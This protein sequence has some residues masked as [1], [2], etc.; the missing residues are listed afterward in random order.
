MNEFI[1][2][3]ICDLELNIDNLPD[4]ANSEI[5][6]VSPKVKKNHTKFIKSNTVNFIK[7]YGIGLAAARNMAIKKCDGDYILLWGN[8]LTAKNLNTII[9]RA[10][11]CCF[12][13]P[14]DRAGIAFRT[15]NKEDNTYFEKCLNYRWNKRFK[16]GASKVIGTPSL[17]KESVLKVYALD[18]KCAYSD[19][20]DLCERLLKDGY[21]VIYSKDC[22][23]ENGMGSF[24]AIK[25]R[26]LM[27]G[28]SDC[29]FYRKY[30][31][32]WTFFRKLKSWLH[33]LTCEFLPNVF[34]LPFY[35]MIV[36][37]RYSG[38]IKESRKD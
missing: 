23:Y 1:S 26:F 9:D 36:F 34:Y 3:I 16:I 15:I 31:R 8:E 11:Y 6:Y 25:S 14:N 38:W 30:S 7:D 10:I 37:F 20:T 29:Q 24:D 27:Y 12:S 18:K 2:I 32:Q 35:F 28:K 33:P 17:W 22:V 13:G 4:V 19:D 5:Y 21:S